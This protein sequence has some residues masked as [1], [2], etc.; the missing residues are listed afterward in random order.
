[1]MA[2]YE[3]I[4]TTT[5]ERPVAFLH[6]SRTR[7]HQAFDTVVREMD[8]KLESSSYAALYSEEGDGFINRD[9]LEKMYLKVATF[10]S[11]DRLRSCKL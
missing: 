3:T 8:E 9:F 7:S 1:M 5:P 2:M 10:M 11:A 4:A 6:S